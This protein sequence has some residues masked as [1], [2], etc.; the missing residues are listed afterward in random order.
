MLQLFSFVMKRIQ[1]HV[2]QYNSTACRVKRLDIY[3]QLCNDEKAIEILK[4][5]GIEID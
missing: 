2:K 5:E 1:H 3:T 4:R